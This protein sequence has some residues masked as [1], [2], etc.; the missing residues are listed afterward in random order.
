MAN[1]GRYQFQGQGV[2]QLFAC[3][4]GLIH[5]LAQHPP[6]DR[7]LIRGQQGFGLVIEQHLAFLYP[8]ILDDGAS[9]G[10]VGLKIFRNG[11][12]RFVKQFQIPHV[13]VN[14][15]KS[16]H[17]TFGKAVIGNPRSLQDFAGRFYFTFAHPGGKQGFVVVAGCFDQGLGYRNGLLGRMGRKNGQYAIRALVAQAG[18]NGQCVLLG[19]ELVGKVNWVGV[20]LARLQNTRECLNAAI[21]KF[22]QLSLVLNEVVGGQNPWATT[23]GDDGQVIAPRARLHGQCLCQVEQLG[24]SIDPNYARPP[25]CGIKSRVITRQG[26]RM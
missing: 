25:K 17:S 5:R 21:R 26:C 22:G 19:I 9:F 16:I 20:E 18:L 2:P 14:A 24:N 13:T 3:F 6:I 8:G 1:V 15:N 12:R 11:G 23:I 7:N 4:G 10:Y